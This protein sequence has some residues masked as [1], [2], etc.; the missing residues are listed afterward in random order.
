M[1]EYQGI[2][3]TYAVCPDCMIEYQRIRTILSIIECLETT[4]AV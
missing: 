3:T 2:Q 1:F 4:Y